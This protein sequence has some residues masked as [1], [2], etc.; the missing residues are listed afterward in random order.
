VAK[1]DPDQDWMLR[2]RAGDDDAFGMLV[3]KYR[4]PVVHLLYRMVHESA[5]AEELAQEVFLRVYR[6]RH[7]YRPQA[8]FS[9]WLFRVATN[10]GLNALRD[11]RMRRT[12]ETSM[13]NAS[14]KPGLA[15]VL[16][17]PAANAEQAV[18]EAERRE[19]IRRAVEALPEKQRLAVLLHKYQ[20][21]S[22]GEIAGVLGCSESALKSLLFR[23][24]ETL[25]VR[26]KPMLGARA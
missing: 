20:E 24:Y 22:Y 1:T 19:Q 13:E 26:L 8:R 2:L 10:V 6:A 18:L 15:A 11:G 25:R 4:D 17:D 3:A 16:A 21:M 9:T 5:V 7:S 12:R 14:D 23:A